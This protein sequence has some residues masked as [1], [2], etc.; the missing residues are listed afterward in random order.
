M[1]TCNKY[2]HNTHIP[3]KKFATGQSVFQTS[4]C[5]NP[6]RKTNKSIYKNPKDV[7][8]RTAGIIGI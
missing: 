8:K 3:L 2:R 6:V 4:A 1:E 5:G 7:W